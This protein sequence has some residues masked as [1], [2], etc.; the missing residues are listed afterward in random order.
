MM[1][2]NNR[3]RQQEHMQFV[4]YIKVAVPCCLLITRACELLKGKVG[5]VC[6][7]LKL[8]KVCITADMFSLS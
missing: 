3:G 7:V 8:T 5:R 6:A 2:I 4:H 1:V